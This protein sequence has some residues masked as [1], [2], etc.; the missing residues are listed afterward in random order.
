MVPE[1]KNTAVLVYHY[2]SG[3]IFAGLVWK[4]DPSWWEMADFNCC[5]APNVD[6]FF[7]FVYFLKFCYSDA[8]TDF[9][10][11]TGADLLVATSCHE[12]R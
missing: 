4:H 3:F 8:F 9:I 1:F 12:P 2:F 6:F 10:L 5:P 7:C 11:T